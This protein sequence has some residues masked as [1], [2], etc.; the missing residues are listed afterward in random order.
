VKLHLIVPQQEIAMFSK[1]AGEFELFENMKTA[2]AG[3][4][5][6]APVEHGEGQVFFS[7]AIPKMEAA[8]GFKPRLPAGRGMSQQMADFSA[9]AEAL[10]MR[11]SLATNL[12]RAHHGL[13]TSQKRKM[14]FATDLHSGDRVAVAAQRVFLDFARAANEPQYH[15]A[16]STGCAAGQTIEAATYTA[17]LECIERD[18]MAIWWY[19][20]QS[21]PHLAPEILDLTQPRLTWWLESRKLET[22]LIDITSNLG[23]P[24][25][26]A[27]SNDANGQTVAIGTAAK[28]LLQDAALAAVTEM[29]QTE[30]AL[31]QAL[32]AG[33]DEALGWC[34]RASVNNQQ[35]FLPDPA[36]GF[37]QQAENDMKSIV[38]RLATFGLHA[39]VVELTLQGDPLHTVR[40]IAPGLCSMQHQVIVERIRLHDGK[41]DSARE[42]ETL[43]PF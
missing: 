2:L 35:Q 1:M 5:N 23:V 15:D 18:A 32:S 6:L 30:H 3:E 8:T 13:F 43:E 40:V 12:H 37:P 42:L 16:D 39:L 11:A 9:A 36:R 41:I 20:K 10:E 17:L 25:V 34:N 4:F 7:T 29:L 31:A 14:V 21:R 19:G 38:D 24:V 27:V 26:A 28:P 22:R 33:D